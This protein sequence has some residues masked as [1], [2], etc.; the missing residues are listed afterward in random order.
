MITRTALAPEN[1]QDYPRPPALEQVDLPVRIV[2]GGTDIAMTDR[3]LRVC[4]THHAPTYYLPPEAFVPG[5]LTPAPGTSFCEWK[6]TAR[7]WSLSGGGVLRRRAAWSYSDP[8]EP[9]LPLRHQIAV[10]PGLMEACFIAGTRVT[11]QPGD[12]Y[13]GWVT[14]NLSGTVKG[15]AGTAWW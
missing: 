11:P 2:L 9:F 10:Y 14:P 6:G 4:E 8:T 7:Y 5:A 1:V 13:G 3:V 12:F 15:A